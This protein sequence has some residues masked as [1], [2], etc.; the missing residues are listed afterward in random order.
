[1]D[2]TLYRTNIM[3]TGWKIGN[4]WYFQA[5]DS[6]KGIYNLFLQHIQPRFAASHNGTVFDRIVAPYWATDV[7]E[8]IVTKVKDM[9][10]YT[11]QFTK[12][13]WGC[14]R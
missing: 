7:D 1:M 13:I 4:F 12:S 14:Y 9:E 11:D 8:V 6:P 5:L 3:R 2:G 10:V